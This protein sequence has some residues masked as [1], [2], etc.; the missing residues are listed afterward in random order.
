MKILIIALVLLVASVGWAD[1]DGHNIKKTYHYEPKEPMPAEIFL[2]CKI[3]E[4]QDSIDKMYSMIADLHI[5][6]M[7]IDRYEQ[8]AFPDDYQKRK[9]W[10][11]KQK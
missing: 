7:G 3:S 9:E 5:K 1:E 6:Q 10:R 2:S 8:I 4:L 11:D